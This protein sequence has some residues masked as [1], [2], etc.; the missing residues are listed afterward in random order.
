MELRLLI[1][2]DQAF[3][4][5]TVR[6]LMAAVGACSAEA[7]G[8]VFQ[9]SGNAGRTAV[10]QAGR[11]AARPAAQY[12]AAGKVAANDVGCGAAPTL[13]PVT[14]VATGLVLVLCG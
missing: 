4:E 3:I 11:K 12:I 9:P 14:R 5:R 13:K 8:R 1:A 6:P 10:V 7:P 2:H